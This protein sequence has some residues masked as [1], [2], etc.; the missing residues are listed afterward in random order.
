M[1]NV[2]IG[3][4]GVI[5]FIGLALAGALILGDDFK[6]AGNDS[7]AAAVISQLQQVSNAIDMSEMKLGSPFMAGTAISTLT[8]RFL[9]A[10]PVDPTGGSTVVAWS[11]TGLG[12]GVPAGMVVLP[13][14]RNADAICSS[15]VQQ[16]GGAAAFP[17]VSAVVDLPKTS[18]GCFKA[19]ASFNSFVTQTH[20]A[21]VR[22]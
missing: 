20:Y 13:M 10:V 12:S 16:T 18:S 1:S 21:F 14:S 7:K 3:I 2:L 8:T 6:A 9:K 15:I 22:T 11:E 19:G 17:T 4:I 5:L